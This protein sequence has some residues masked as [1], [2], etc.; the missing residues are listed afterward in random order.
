MREGEE[1]R[2][3]G[4]RGHGTGERRG[5]RTAPLMKIRL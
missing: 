3:K 2:Q 4:E 5:D 1:G